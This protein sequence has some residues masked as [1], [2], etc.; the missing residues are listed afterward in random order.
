MKK[1]SLIYILSL[2]L[3]I[4][5]VF[6]ASDK[7]HVAATEEFNTANPSKTINVRVIEEGTLG[8]HLLKADDTIHCNIVKVTD[9]K[10][11]KRAASFAVCPISYTS[12]GY[13]NQIKENYY[14]KYAEKVL[15][16]EELKNVDAMKVGKKAAVSVGNHFVKGVA[17]AISLA[18]GM[19]KNEEGNRLESG[20]K[21]VYKDSPLSYAEK[22]QELK[23]KPGDT[24][25][26]IFKPSKSKNPSDIG[27]DVSEE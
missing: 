18:E 12:D 25:Y 15:S 11:G 4:S 10:R 23:I 17:P 13:T 16:K 3:S 21:Q 8:S 22:G 20:M 19:V 5:T 6:A 1:K 24:F 14:G 27:E 7:I 9:P 2:F 26:L